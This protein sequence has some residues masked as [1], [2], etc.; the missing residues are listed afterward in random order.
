MLMSAD[1]LA[2]DRVS[3]AQP[4]F[5][6]VR[7]TS[8]TTYGDRLVVVGTDDSNTDSERAAV[9]LSDDGLA[10]LRVPHDETTFGADGYQIPVSVTSFD[11]GLVAVGESSAL[12]RPTEAA[13]WVSSD[14]TDWRRITAQDSVFSDAIMIDVTAF[15]G[16]LVAVGVDISGSDSDA[17]VWTS[18]NGTNWTRVAHDETQFGGDGSQSM[19]SV[20]S[21]NGRLVAVGSDQPGIGDAAVWTSTDAT[22]WTRIPHDESVLGGGE[23]GAA[24]MTSVEAYGHGFVAGGLKQSFGSASTSGDMDAVVW[25]SPNG[26]VWE[27]ITSEESVFGGEDM[28][29]IHSLAVLDESIVVV[30]QL[31]PPRFLDRGDAVI[32]RLVP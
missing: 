32:W 25:I 14:G 10:W 27:R 24:E 22:I 6:D 5:R 21:S 17:A 18:P 4:V 29:K 7:L 19:D 2:W 23:G 11:G 16:L 3:P 31:S 8:I 1:G 12:D 13:V 30:G 20:A 28:Q 15:G 9:W 26:R